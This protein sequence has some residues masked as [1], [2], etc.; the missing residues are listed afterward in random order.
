[1]SWAMAGSRRKRKRSTAE[2]VGEQ[3]LLSFGLLEGLLP[4]QGSEL[5]QAIVGPGTDQAEQVADLAVRLDTVEASAGEQ[6]NEDGIDG[7]S[8]VAADEEPVLPTEGTAIL[9]SLDAL[10]LLGSTHPLRMLLHAIPLLA[11][12]DPVCDG[13]ERTDTAIRDPRR[14]V[15]VLLRPNS[16]KQSSRTPSGRP[17]A[18]AQKRSSAAVIDA[19]MY[20]VGVPSTIVSFSECVG[21]IKTL[22]P[23]EMSRL[24]TDVTY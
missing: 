20:S 6:R 3:L 24:Y 13:A 16:I 14:T 15:E 17:T 10:L 5:E 11:H 18:P 4:I 19:L 7:G 8:V 22:R 1:M 9:P 12:A 23:R 21:P 2:D